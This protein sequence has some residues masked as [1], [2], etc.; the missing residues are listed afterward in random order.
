MNHHMRHVSVSEDVRRLLVENL[1]SR[2]HGCAMWARMTLEY[3]VT[4]A[5][6]TSVDSVKSYLKKNAP[7]KPLTELYLGVFENMTRDDDECKWLLSRSL[8]LIAP[9]GVR[10]SYL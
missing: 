9:G 6:R 3:L 1:T 4:G 8:A 7:P 10:T 2:M 5:R